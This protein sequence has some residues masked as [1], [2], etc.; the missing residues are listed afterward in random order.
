MNAQDA[1]ASTEDNGKGRALR[2]MRHKVLLPAAFLACLGTA[3]VPLSS[4]AKALETKSADPIEQAYQVLGTPYRYGGKSPATGFD[5]SGLVTHVF[6]QSLGISLPHN[7]SAQ[8]RLGIRVRLAELAPGDLVFYNTRRR[9]YS[10]VGIYIGDD[11]FI[12]APR[13]GSAVRVE[14]M[15]TAYWT[16]RYNGSRRIAVF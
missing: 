3:G 8:S 2:I 4:S 5:C 10:H 14:S 11:K 1:G 13:S 7:A 16:K 6:E 9:P 15:K 12:H